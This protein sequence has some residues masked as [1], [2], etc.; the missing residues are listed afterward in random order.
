MKI[1]GLGS[2]CPPAFLYLIISLIV[3]GVIAFQNAGNTDLH[4]VGPYSCSVSSTWLIFLLEVIYIVFWAWI[5][6]IFCSAGY[7]WLSWLFVLVPFIV[8]FILI[9]T[10]MIYPM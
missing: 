6:N 9:L 4:S 8:F 10:V 5:L 7:T 3:L 2:I 1:T